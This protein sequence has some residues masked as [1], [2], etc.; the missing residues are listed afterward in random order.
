MM[1][2]DMGLLPQVEIALFQE[3]GEPWIADLLVEGSYVGWMVQ[4]GDDVIG[5]GGLHLRPHG[6]VPGCLESGMG[7][8][9][10]NVYIEP[11]HRRRGLAEALM[12]CILDWARSNN[13]KELTLTASEQGRSLYQ[14]LG[15]VSCPEFHALKLY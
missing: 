5:G 14:R 2:Y 1:F 3:A 10:A 11:A 4:Y 7:A 9:I 13:L 6:P 8:H 12:T 15:F